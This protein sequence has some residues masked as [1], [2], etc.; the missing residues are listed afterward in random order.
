MSLWCKVI[1]F[2]PMI[3]QLIALNSS[4]YKWTGFIKE[5]SD[6]IITN[7]LPGPSITFTKG[8]GPTANAIKKQFWGRVTTYTSRVGNFRPV[9]ERCCCIYTMHYSVA[10]YLCPILFIR[11]FRARS[12]FCFCVFFLLLASNAY[13]CAV[14]MTRSCR[15]YRC[16]LR[17]LYVVRVCLCAFFCLSKFSAINVLHRPTVK[18]PIFVLSSLK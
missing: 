2:P 17:S 15:C 7:S 18:L 3:V 4:S 12:S 1:V 14:Q 6:K 11:C 13:I 5:I 10:V 16:F 8:K 9:H